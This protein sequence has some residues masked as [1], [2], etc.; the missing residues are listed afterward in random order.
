MSVLF[1]NI[2]VRWSHTLVTIHLYHGNHHFKIEDEEEEEEEEED[3]RRNNTARHASSQHATKK[4]R[5]A[6]HCSTRISTTNLREN[7]GIIRGLTKP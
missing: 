1:V 6:L 5:C 7:S 2:G 4:R 3:R